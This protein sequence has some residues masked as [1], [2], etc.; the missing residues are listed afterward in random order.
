MLCFTH[1]RTTRAFGCMPKS[2]P[3]VPMVHAAESLDQVKAVK[4]CTARQGSLSLSLSL[5]FVFGSICP[6]NTEI[7][8]YPVTSLGTVVTIPYIFYGLPHPDRHGPV[9]WHGRSG[10]AW[11]CQP[12]SEPSNKGHRYERS[13]DATSS[14]WPYY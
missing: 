10:S 14:S 4:L 12:R 11:L 2:M 1:C 3:L 9:T 7:K 13:K 5:I 8:G 6:T